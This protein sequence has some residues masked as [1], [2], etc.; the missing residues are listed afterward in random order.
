MV[1]YNKNSLVDEEKNSIGLLTSLLV[2]YPEVCSLNYYSWE[3]CLKLIFILRGKLKKSLLEK[4]QEELII[5]VRT[6]LYFEKKDIPR[7]IRIKYDYESDLTR[8]II[9]R[10]ADT[11]TQEEI[12]LII[13]LLHVRFKNLLISDESSNFAEEDLLLQDNYIKCMLDN[14]HPQKFK[15]EIIALRE[16][17]RVLVFK[18]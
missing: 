5:C 3:N 13:N 7:Q 12:S 18:H 6:Y 8:I 17:G 1:A 15:N 16:E 11:L 4:F 2:R 10:D 14:L 9:T